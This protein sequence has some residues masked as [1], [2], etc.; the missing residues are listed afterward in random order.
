MARPEHHE[1]RLP[2]IEKLRKLGWSTDQIVFE[3]EWRVPKTPHD[4][5]KREAGLKYESWPIDIAVF[6]D[7]KHVRDYRHLAIIIETK[8]PNRSEGRAQLEIYFRYEPHAKCGIWT[9]GSEICVLYRAADGTFV[10]DRKGSIPK[11]SD[12]LIYAA[13]RRAVFADLTLPDALELRKKFVRLLQIVVARDTRSTRRDDQ[14]NELCNLL[15]TK[16]ES[17]KA[18]A[19]D[20]ESTVVFQVHD[21]EKATADRIQQL[22]ADLRVT[23]N[24]LFSQE[25]YNRVNL[26]DH[27]IAVA[28]Y[29]LGMMRLKDNSVGVIAEAFQVFRAAALKS[30]E[31]QYFTPQPVIRS[32]VRFLEIRPTDNI[33]DPA[34][35]TGGFLSAIEG[36]QPKSCAC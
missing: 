33:I 18:G 26:D 3:P 24:D 25:P 19:F 6:D 5:S 23:H 32:A 35:G 34:C 2:F 22:F 4:A 14:L 29:E 17:D 28:A 36:A 31:G 12:S 7:P 8:A 10:D 16:L 20:P 13:K 15:L 27:T 21:T 11:Q 30:E 9:N 1:V